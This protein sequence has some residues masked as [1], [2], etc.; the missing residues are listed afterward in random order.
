MSHWQIVKTLRGYCSSGIAW[1]IVWGS[2]TRW[3]SNYYDNYLIEVLKSLH[4][5][6]KLHSMLRMYEEQ[7][8]VYGVIVGDGGKTMIVRGLEIQKA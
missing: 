5:L 2:I 6:L 1:H 3:I 4:I 8:V 7:P